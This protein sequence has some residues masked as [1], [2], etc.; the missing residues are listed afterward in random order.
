MNAR[1]CSLRRIRIRLAAIALAFVVC[2]VIGVMCALPEISMAEPGAFLAEERMVCPMDGTV[3][4]QPSALSSPE[5]QVKPG[6]AANVVHGAILL[7]PSVDLMIPSSP[8]PCSLGSALS[9]VPL[10]IRSSPV[11]RI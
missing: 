10:S 9:I 5:R 1:L 7:S 8:M 4:C 3:M 6:A 2:Q 11:L